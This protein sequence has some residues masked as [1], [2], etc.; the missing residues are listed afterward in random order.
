MVRSVVYCSVYTNNREST[1]NTSFGCFF[2]TSTNC[3]DVFFR[4]S[5]TNNFR[6]EFECFFSV[7]VHRLE[8]NFTVSVLTTSTGLFSVL[9]ID[10]NSF[11]EGFFVCYLWSTNV[12]FY[13]ELTKKTVNDDFKVKLTHTSDDCLSCFLICMSTESRIFFCKFCKSFCHLAL[14]SFCLRLDSE[15][16]NWI[17]EFHRLKNYRMLFVTDCITSSCELESNSCCDIS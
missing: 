3:R 2:D 15:L 5:T 14:S 7:N 10:I 9:R 12:S 17:W 13:F 11:C 16:D 1:K 4:N 6:I 8:T